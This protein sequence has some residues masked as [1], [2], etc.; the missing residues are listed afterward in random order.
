MKKMM[1][2]ATHRRQTREERVAV[3]RRM[4][5]PAY[6]P[7]KLDREWV[8]LAAAN[9]EKPHVL[10]DMLGISLPT[11]QKHHGKDYRTGLSDSNLKVNHALFHMAVGHEGI[12]DEKKKRW[13]VRPRAP[14]FVAAQWWDRTRNKK[15]EITRTELTGADGAEL[16]SAPPVVI[17]IPPNGRETGANGDPTHVLRQQNL[18][19]IEAKPVVVEMPARMNGKGNGKAAHK[20]NGKG[21]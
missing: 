18:K 1:Q 5:A 21:K 10:A 19:L 20:T 17:F 7:S 3:P 4:P 14:D 15:T 9:G 6:V 13:V 16:H 8:K 2:Q 12:W 11:F